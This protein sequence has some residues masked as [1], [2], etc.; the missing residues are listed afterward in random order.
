MGP[1]L[2]P[3]GRSDG[4]QALSTAQP[5]LARVSASRS[6]TVRITS[7]S[8]KCGTGERRNPPRLGR[9]R[10]CDR[11]IIGARS[12]SGRCRRSKRRGSRPCVSFFGCDPSDLCTTVATSP[13]GRYPPRA[14]AE[15]IGEIRE[16]VVHPARGLT[17][18]P[19]NSSRRSRAGGGENPGV[20]QLQHRNS[21]A[22]DQTPLSTDCPSAQKHRL[23][24]RAISPVSF[25]ARRRPC[26]HLSDRRR[27]L[28]WRPA[29]RHAGWRARRTNPTW[30]PPPRSAPSARNCPPR[31]PPGHR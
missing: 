8:A 19:G 23:N 4:Y 13:C 28:G 15:V 31:S 12:I 17:T 1:A 7:Q 29:R 10:R 9:D 18:S 5:A 25:S 22:A 6:S 30:Y 14:G 3:R 27:R 21:G 26:V 16:H 2:S 20:D 24:P 11:E